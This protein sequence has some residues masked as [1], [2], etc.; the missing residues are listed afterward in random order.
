MRI[1]MKGVTQRKCQL[2]SVQQEHL[3]I[4]SL[5]QKIGREEK[6]AFVCYVHR[7][8]DYVS[9]VEPFKCCWLQSW[10][11]IKAIYLLFV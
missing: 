5:K 9:P 2:Y 6:M 7:I 3:K 10:E 1:E 4:I 8:W 11:N